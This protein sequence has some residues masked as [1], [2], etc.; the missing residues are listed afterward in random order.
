MI[1]LLYKDLYMAWK[2][3]RTFLLLMVVFWVVYLF[4]DANA[5]YLLYPCALVGSIP[6]SLVA[7]DERTHWDHFA[8]SLPFRRR[9]LV[10]GKYLTALVLG[11]SVTVAMA[12]AVL[13]RMMREGGIQ[14]MSF[15][16]IAS[17]L[18]CASLAVPS[19]LLPFVFK[20]GAE[21]GRMAYFAVVGIACAIC[22]LIIAGEGLA[23]ALDSGWMLFGLPVLCLGLAVLS[24]WLSIRFY[25]K[26]EL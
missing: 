12:L 5:F 21:K 10:L 7:Y 17:V 15:F 9:Q 13:G 2:Y 24:L 20:F 4:G 19:L 18:V 26:R 3:C 11:G 16:S 23:I 25:E 14:W 22:A 8:A 1:A 6:M